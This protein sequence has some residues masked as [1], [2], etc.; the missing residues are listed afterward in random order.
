MDVYIATGK[1][2]S[3]VLTKII[4]K[5]FDLT[6]DTAQNLITHEIYGL[7]N[8][9][10]QLKDNTSFL[11]ETNYVDK[12][13]RDSYYHYYSSKLNIYK[14]N[15]IRISIFEGE[16]KAED[17]RNKNKI[18]DLKKSYRGFIVL[19]PTE[20]SIIGRSLISPEA[21]KNNKFFTCTTSVPTTVHSIKLE[22]KGFPH[23]SQDGETI[24]CAETTVWALME[25]FSHKY[26]QYKSVLPSNIISVL[27]SVSAERQ[28]PSRGLNIEQMSYALK[29]FGFGTRIYSRQEYGDNFENILSCYIESGI[30][31]IV[32]VETPSGITPRIGHAMLCTGYEPRQDYMINSLSKTFIRSKKLKN[33]IDAKKIK[34]FDNDDIRRKFI[35]IDDNFPAYQKN[36]LNK[37]C[38]NYN[39]SIYPNWGTCILTHF[40]VPLYSKI[41]LEAFQAKSFVRSFLIEGPAPLKDDSEIFLRTYLTSSRSYKNWLVFSDF[42]PI[43][44][45]E[46]VLK[47]PMPKFVWITEITTR[48]LMKGDNPK[49]EGI[50]VLDATEPNTF[51]NKA[52]IFA[53]YQNRQIKYSEEKECFEDISIYLPSFP[54]FENLNNYS[55]G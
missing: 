9:I 26:P 46:Y 48:E 19:R 20:P 3:S 7:K 21:L 38:E 36:S 44:L 18:N 43:D 30:P 2:Y 35:F 24:S 27:N 51:N 14:R 15:C 28:I 50:V 53:A 29:E 25:Y 39:P 33:V 23:S 31:L 1:D 54:I 6:N 10:A 52:L 32:A 11:I 40:L 42:N 13:Y 4:R 49:A 34:I 8:H 47:L 12:V 37:P 17:F 55:N 5:E 16:I 45:K 41:Y 22:V